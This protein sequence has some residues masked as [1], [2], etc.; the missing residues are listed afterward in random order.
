MPQPRTIDTNAS[1]VADLVDTIR[2]AASQV[3]AQADRLRQ[4]AALIEETS[5]EDIVKPG[6]AQNVMREVLSRSV[7]AAK[8]SSAETAVILATRISFAAVAAR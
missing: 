5:M 4:F 7:D 3:Q 2:N 8:Q 6:L 1:D